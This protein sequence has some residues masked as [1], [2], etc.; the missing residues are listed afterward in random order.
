MLFR[1]SNYIASTFAMS[2]AKD[3]VN[4]LVAP[5]DVKITRQAYLYDLLIADRNVVV[6][7][8]DFPD[9]TLASL[10]LSLYVPT[11]DEFQHFT[12]QLLSHDAMACCAVSFLDLPD[13]FDSEEEGGS[14]ND[15][16]RDHLKGVS[17]YAAQLME[18]ERIHGFCFVRKR[19]KEVAL[20]YNNTVFIC[21]LNPFQMARPERIDLLLQQLDEKD[22]VGFKEVPELGFDGRLADIAKRMIKDTLTHKYRFELEFPYWSAVVKS[23]MEVVYTHNFGFHATGIM[24]EAY[25]GYLNSIYAKNAAGDDC[26][27]VSMLKVNELENWMRAW[28][29]MEGCGFMSNEDAD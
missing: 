16:T 6:Y 21:A 4:V 20:Y 8:P 2:S 12:N 15:Y 22:R 19:W 29:F 28:M 13:W 7:Q 10:R 17:A 27:D 18:A 26:E 14:L 24:R 23:G 5:M 1:S 9:D 11:D 25:S 3:I